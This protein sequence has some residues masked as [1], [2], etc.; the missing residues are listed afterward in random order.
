M[1]P[2]MMLYLVEQVFVVM[3]ELGNTKID[4]DMDLVFL[5]W[6]SPSY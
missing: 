1:I 2:N 3:L 6:S 5:S 4:V